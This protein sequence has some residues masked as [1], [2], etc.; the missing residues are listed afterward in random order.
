[1]NPSS[2]I[3]LK[4]LLN[5]SSSYEKLIGYL[6]TKEQERLNKIS[7]DKPFDLSQFDTTNILNEVHYSWF[8]PTLESI[9]AVQDRLI[10]MSSLSPTLQEK[11]KPS[12]QIKQDIIDLSDGAKEYARLILL[13][14]LIGEE[15][16]LLPAAYLPPS[17]MNFLL[18]LNKQELMQLVDFLG[19]YDLAADIKKIVD[20][21]A[22]RS[23][24][25]CLTPKQKTFLSGIRTYQDPSSFPSMLKEWDKKKETFHKLLHKKGLNRLAIALC[26]SHPDLLWYVSH[27]L[28]KGRGS[29]LLKLTKK[30]ANNKTITMIRS[31]ILDII[32]LMRK[33]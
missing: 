25:S 23:I 1:M 22:I 6:S 13:S 17:R 11:L 21:K 10:L 18:T 15:D 31:H 14:S 20:T 8:I 4:T 27:F 16:T 28:D 29:T 26:T 5:T 32:Q 3:V 9:E 12:L 33:S 19:L 30:K 2:Y 7:I 24:S